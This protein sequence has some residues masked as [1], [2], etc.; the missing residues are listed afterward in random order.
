MK[1]KNIEMWNKISLSTWKIKKK[2]I[3]FNWFYFDEWI[4]IRFYL[5]KMLTACAASVYLLDGNLIG[6]EKSNIFESRRRNRSCKTELKSEQRC[7]RPATMAQ[8]SAQVVAK[9]AEIEDK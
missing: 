2:I 7:W 6:H 4:R 3:Q 1:K 9:N 8:K 5:I